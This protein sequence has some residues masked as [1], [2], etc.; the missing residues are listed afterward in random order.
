MKQVRIAGR[1]DRSSHSGVGW[2]L[3]QKWLLALALLFPAL[4][5]STSLADSVSP[6]SVLVLYSFSERSIS[7]FLEPLKSA[8]RARA[9]WPINFNVEYL[10]TQSF[11]D[12]SYEQSLAASLRYK[13]G[14]QRLDLVMVS[15]YPALHFA[16][17][18]RS[19]LFPGVPIVF[20]DVDPGRIRTIK[21][22]WPGV[23]GVTNTT[24]VRETINL[25]LHLHPDTN[26]IAVIT[27]TSEFE[28]YWLAAVHAELLRHQDKVT[29][30]DL[31]G[32][33]TD[34]LLR[35]VAALHPHTV[36]LFQLA[37]QESSQPEIG[38]YDVLANVAQHLP[39]YC[40]FPIL[41]LDRGG[42]G[43]ADM[44]L[45]E[46]FS[47]VAELAI[48]VLSGEQP[49]SIPVM[50]L[51]ASKVR[52]DWRQLRRWKIPESALPP[53]SEVLYRQPTLWERDRKYILAAIVLIVAQ[54]LLIVG[55]L[56]QRARKRKAEAVLRESEK[57]FRVMADTTPSLI[58]MCDHQGKVTY[59]NDRRVAFTGPTS[60][61]GYGDT[62]TAYVHP[63]DLKSV[64]DAIA[65]G[66]K[67]RAPFSKEYRL[68]RR[69]GVYRWMF[70]VASPRVN[71]DRSFAG[72]I[73]SAIDVTDQKL[74]Q[75]ALENVSGRLI[76][77]QENERSRIA[78]ELHDDICQ[79]L[80]LLS[81]EL[82][83]ANRTLNGSSDATEQRLEEIRKHCSDIAGDVQSLSHQLHSSKLDY[84]GI[85]AAVRG[86]CNEFAK[87][88]QVDI[89]FTDQ[90]VPRY[91]PKDVSLC[92]F[93]VAQEALH[94][95]LKYSGT[96]QLAV[97]MRGT[98]DEVRLMV[99]D[100]GAGFN[101]E[102]AKK[103]RGLGLVS[104]QERVHL[105]HGRFSVESRCGAGTKIV[106]VVPV[107]AANAESSVDVP[108]D[109][110]AGAGAA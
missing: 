57:R 32:P 95:A 33:P 19:E 80:A 39:T 29:E 51:S 54:S 13:Y 11:E 90:N 45:N 102:E 72:F 97:E 105:V 22:M 5:H 92:L 35:N 71:G 77:A 49:Q 59:L 94:N 84:L 43:G 2:L 78:R 24:D 23:T 109:Q 17:K 85:V 30:V 52:V 93:R 48:R 21:Q 83:Q 74:A 62:W 76:E 14:A 99:M 75:E 3:R 91:L 88:H 106:A 28:R 10:E 101:V 50:H 100:E 4:V 56:L 8:L 18:H 41:C 61:A 15:A 69:D 34:Q 87:Q 20:F 73:G 82:E 37:P 46:Q 70:D 110:A 44:D 104:M 9:S 86:F 79:R 36:V 38:V 16:L 68:R 27:N 89:Q 31:V 81:M 1:R 65:Q 7:H 12:E 64:L 58:W 53:G 67:T 25:A 55:L 6:K 96:S 47:A 26:T 63:D 42:I 98:S 103:N 60:Q 40:I 107:P 66:L 108:A